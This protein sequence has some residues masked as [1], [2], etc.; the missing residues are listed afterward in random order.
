MT[1]PS[2]R[3]RT[4]G[5]PFDVSTR[6]V[7]VRHGE[8]TCGV[9][10]IVGGP[11]GC[12]GL[13]DK[14]VAQAKQLFARLCDTG[15]LQDASSLYSSVLPRA[16]E[17]CE[18]IRPCVGGGSLRPVQDCGLCEIHPGE[19]DAMTWG[20]YLDRF[21]EPDWDADPTRP[22]APGGES[23]TSFVARAAGAVKRLADLNRGSK[24]V[25][26][27]HAGVIE[28]TMIEFLGLRP[29]RHRLQ[30]RTKHTSLTEWERGDEG[31]RLLRYND[32]AH[33]RAL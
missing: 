22:L 9:T 20:E 10:G 4:T 3:V 29:P 12:S 11:I 8:A 18:M 6:V 32:A 26:V 30:L 23:W 7:L 1:T 21:E 14:G 24:I 15:E 13:T 16:I 2:T 28:A 25:V 17:T 31:W 19:A 33:L 5:T 27:C